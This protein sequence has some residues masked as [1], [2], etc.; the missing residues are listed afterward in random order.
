MQVIPY[1]NFPD[2]VEDARAFYA[3]AVLATVTNISRFGDMASS[4]C[5]ATPDQIMH[6]RITSP[7]GVD[8]VLASDGGRGGEMLRCARSIAIA[9]STKAHALFAALSEGGEVSM[10]ISTQFWGAGFGM[11]KDKSSV[12]WI[13]NCDAPAA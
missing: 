2:L 6:G 11:F 4:H 5:N 8:V 9:D 12:Q 7:D 13:V 1:F 10:P 3:A